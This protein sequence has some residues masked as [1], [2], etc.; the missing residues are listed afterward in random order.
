MGFYLQCHQ[1]I[2]RDGN[3]L[4]LL[5]NGI[6]CFAT[7]VFFEFIL[8]FLLSSYP[9]IMSYHEAHCVTMTHHNMFV[10]GKNR[11]ISVHG[12]HPKMHSSK[13]IDS[14]GLNRKVQIYFLWYKGT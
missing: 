5:M 11:E 7:Y 12:K 6:F 3:I 4:F 1:V 8:F 13:I 14:Q 10:Q 9:Y 2:N